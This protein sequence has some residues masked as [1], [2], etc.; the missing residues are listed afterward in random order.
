M[1]FK[2]FIYLFMSFNI[3]YIEAH[4]S[5]VLNK[6]LYSIDNPTNE[7]IIDA[8]ENIINGRS[9]E[10][11]NC[12]YS[13][14]MIKQSLHDDEIVIELFVRLIVSAKRYHHSGVSGTIVAHQAVPL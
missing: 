9:V 3:I 11:F 12:K 6:I 4:E 1:K 13:F 5:F 2:F 8:Y 10:K 14:D 7:N